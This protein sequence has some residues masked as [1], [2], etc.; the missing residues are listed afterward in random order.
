MKLLGMYGAPAEVY[1]L[2]KTFRDPAK[3]VTCASVLSKPILFKPLASLA[4]RREEL[5]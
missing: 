1:G 3:T 2:A 4:L 5:P